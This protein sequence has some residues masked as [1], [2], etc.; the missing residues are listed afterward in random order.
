VN[1]VGEA[2]ALGALTFCGA[3]MEPV[4]IGAAWVVGATVTVE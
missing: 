1:W 4:D 2:V 3:E